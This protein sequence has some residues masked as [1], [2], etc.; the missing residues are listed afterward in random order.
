MKIVISSSGKNLDS[1]LDPRFG[2]CA[3]FLLVDTNDMSFEIF[4]ND[5]IALGGGAGIQAAQFVNTKGPVAV[6]TGN[7]GPNAFQTLSTAGI[8]V[9]LGNTGTVRK[10]L[11]AY[12]NGDLTSADNANAPDHSGIGTRRGM[13]M[14]RGMGLSTAGKKGLKRNK[15]TRGKS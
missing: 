1:M 11:E 2:R 13:G 15:Q 9:F 14:G 5:N 6:I 12:L 7:C 3:Y 8:E 4:D 10:A